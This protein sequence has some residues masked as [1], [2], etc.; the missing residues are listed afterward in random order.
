MLLRIQGFGMKIPRAT[1]PGPGG[2]G[3]EG[4]RGVVGSLLGKGWEL[5]CR[6]G[7]SVS[8]ESSGVWDWDQMVTVN[9]VKLGQGL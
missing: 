8:K 4:G 1:G 5:G 2:R 7:V 3:H 6:W 9:W